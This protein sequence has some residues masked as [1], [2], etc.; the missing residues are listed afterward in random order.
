MKPRQLKSGAWNVRIMVEGQ[1]YS[2]THADKKTA[3]RMAAEFAD[4]HRRRIEN[5]TLSEA[6]RDYIRDNEERLS[7]STIRSYE[8]MFRMILERTP[9]IAGKRVSALTEQDILNIVRPLRT[10]KTKRNYINFIHA[11]T[12]KGVNRKLYGT[13][14]KRVHVPTELEVLGLLQLFRNTDLEVPIM[15]AAYGGLRRGEICALKMSD[16]DGD[17]VHVSKAVVRDPQGAWVTKEPKTPSSIRTVLL[18]RFV[19]DR[20]R[21]QGY[22][23]HM[24][25]SNV[26]NRFWKRQ[27]NLGIRPYCFH[28]LRHFHAS[29]LHAIGIPDAYVQKRGGWSSAATLQNVYRHAL[30]D[31]ATATDLLAVAAFQNPFQ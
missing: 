16:I 30:A 29:Y 26:S 9:K 17:F 4:E 27:R 2:F 14:S 21:E 22:I 18:P 5:P 8:G 19:I 20:I 28:S 25:P 24:L 31:Y 23:T 12:G 11:A 7:P 1:S 15:L 13:A 10:L 3:L 6:L